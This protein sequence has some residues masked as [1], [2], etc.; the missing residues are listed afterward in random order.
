MVSILSGVKY[1][2]DSQ[3]KETLKLYFSVIINKFIVSLSDM[4]I[5]LSV[6]NYMSLFIDKKTQRIDVIWYNK[7]KSILYLVQMYI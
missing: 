2:G 4:G 3:N 7:F 5:R 6:T 1:R